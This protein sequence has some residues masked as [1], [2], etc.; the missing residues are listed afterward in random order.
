MENAYSEFPIRTKDA[1][2]G[3]QSVGKREC[4]RVRCGIAKSIC[5]VSVSGYIC[6]EP[7]ALFCGFI[8]GSFGG[9][10]R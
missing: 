9:E 10:S 6:N 8:I 2:V 5:A 3:L 7:Q 4:T 1:K